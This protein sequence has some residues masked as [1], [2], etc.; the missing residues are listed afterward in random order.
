MRLTIFGGLR[1]LEGEDV[2]ELGGRKQRGAVKVPV[3]V[4]AA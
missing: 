2:L 4:G 1:V 3:R